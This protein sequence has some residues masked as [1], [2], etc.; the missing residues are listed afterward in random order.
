MAQEYS[1]I[2]GSVPAM[3]LSPRSFDA[4]PFPLLPSV[5]E[6]D[7]QPDFLEVCSALVIPLDMILVSE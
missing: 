7:L 6:A 5:Q 1:D 2:I 4:A 3:G